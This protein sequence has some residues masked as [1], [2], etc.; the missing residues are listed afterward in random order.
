MVVQILVATPHLPL[1]KLVH[2]LLERNGAYQTQICALASEALL[3]CQQETFSIAIL[4][5][6]LSDLP[7]LAFTN[8]LRR[9]YPELKL[10]VFP[11][12]NDPHAL[13]LAG[14]SPDACLNKPFYLPDL[15]TTITT[16]MDN[17]GVLPSPAPAEPGPL[18]IFSGSPELTWLGPQDLV[19]PMKQ[20][21]SNS[22]AQ[23]AL[24][25]RQGATRAYIG[26]PSQ[27]HADELAAQTTRQWDSQDHGDLVRYIRLGNSDPHYLFYATRLTGDLV[28]TVLYKEETPFSRARAQIRQSANPLVEIISAEGRYPNRPESGP[29]IPRPSPSEPS[30]DLP[31][32]LTE[33]DGEE[34][35]APIE[36]L[37]PLFPDVP[38]PRP[39]PLDL[40]AR[41]WVREIDEEAKE[42]A[43]SEGQDSPD[44]PD[45]V[46]FKLVNQNAE[47]E[48][49]APQAGS[50]PKAI[51]PPRPHNLLTPV[52][53]GIASLT[54]TAVLVPRLPQHFLA[55]ELATYM[56][57][58]MP[59]LCLAFGWTLEGLAL[60]PSHMEW[61]VRLAPMVAPG[62]MLRVVRQ[63]TSQRV[64]S[65]FPDLIED[66]P[67]GDFWSPGYLIV[68]G[69]RSLPPDLLQEYV[70]RTRQQ[71]EL[72]PD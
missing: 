3:L 44:T 38:A 56:S 24:I 23:A 2:Q 18:E 16:L 64:F 62:K 60:R 11:P 48:S 68:S 5:S 57:Q 43:T 19:E 69:T 7:F 21:L 6:D 42:T 41:G 59:Q 67:S 20:F 70:N 10:V 33:E 35:D 1:G 54:Y 8:E 46:G 52:S 27:A 61:V 30:E 40:A 72:K 51:R 28:L 47:E 71:Q 55:G 14:I 29:A 49:E 22:G 12:G 15:L 17:T 50:P 58:W 31:E 13:S 45:P 53:S 32:S 25:W 26:Y 39:D 37:A 65:A 63:H 36:N 34:D 4:D 9:L 66:N